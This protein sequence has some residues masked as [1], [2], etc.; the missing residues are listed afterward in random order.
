MYDV[1]IIGA[2]PA[3][4]TAGI[5]AAR[6]KLKTLILTKEVG[7]Q[8]GWSLDMENYS[9]FTVIDG[10]S[11]TKKFRDH[12][13]SIPEDLELQK[14]VEVTN[15]EKNITTF[16][17]QDKTGFIHYGKSVI[18]AS[19]KIPK[20]L[21]IPGEQKFYGKGVATCAIY[22][23]P[24]YKNKQVVVIGD[25]NS[26]MD[27]VLVLSKSAKSVTVVNRG[28]A[29]EGDAVLKNKISS[30]PHVQFLSNHKVL[31]ITGERVA[32]GVIVCD[33]E[34]KQKN[35]STEGIF[36]EIGYDP[37]VLFDTVT[38]KN[39]L[40]EIKVGRNMETSVS[41]IFA[42]GDVNDARG[43]QIIIAAGEGAKAAMAAADFLHK[44]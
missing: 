12:L 16:S 18:I 31:E 9:G 27:A 42:A 39:N 35:I 22:D 10:V 29:M 15:I 7:G 28:S 37:E 13:E 26:A 41:G 36:L 20:Q 19:G 5:Y 32:T 34:G 23:A 4:M 14:G 6:K 1:I 33:A 25:G 2:G 3:G 40:N 8:M 43:D 44:N 24:L 30:L 38:E 17:V 21:G 11:L